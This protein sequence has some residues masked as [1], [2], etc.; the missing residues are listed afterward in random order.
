MNRAELAIV[1]ILRAVG[2]SGLFAIPAI[3]LPFTWMSFIHELLGLG[4]MP[5]GPIVLYLARSL[6]A[7]YAFVSAITLF[8]SFDIS[9]YQSF[10]KLWAS[11][12]ILLGIVLL[13]IDVTAGMPLSWTLFE[14]PPTLAVGLLVLWLQG[15]IDAPS[16]K[17]L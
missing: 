11:L 16:Q 15:R 10:V 5:S 8:V 12:V 7:F 2:I 4:E 1:I 14:G 17:V 6:S 13:G 3:F 9:R